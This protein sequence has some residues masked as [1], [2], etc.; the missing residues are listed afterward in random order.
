[1]YPILCSRI[2]TMRQPSTA[3][4]SEASASGSANTTVV[5]TAPNGRKVKSR[6]D[7]KDTV[8]QVTSFKLVISHLNKIQKNYLGQVPP[9]PKD[10]D[11]VESECFNHH[12][13]AGRKKNGVDNPA[14][15]WRHSKV[16]F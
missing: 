2:V 5:N 8:D 3:T 13:E 14:F 16:K 12:R 9:I 1:M 15:R 10:P 6:L 11:S 7:R 4:Q